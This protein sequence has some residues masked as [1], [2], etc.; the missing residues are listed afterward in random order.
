MRKEIEVRIHEWE[1]YIVGQEKKKLS[2]RDDF[3][4]GIIGGTYERDKKLAQCQEDIQAAE[5]EIKALKSKLEQSD[6]SE[7]LSIKQR[8]RGETGHETFEMYRDA[9][10]HAF[11][12][13]KADAQN[14]I[15]R[16]Q[17]AQNV[18][19]ATKPET[20]TNRFDPWSNVENTYTWF[21]GEFKS[22]EE[23]AF[24]I[25]IALFGGISQ[26]EIFDAFNDIKH[27]LDIDLSAKSDETFKSPTADL[28]EVADADF[29]E[30]ERL[31]NA[32]FIKTTAINFRD[33]RASA[34]IMLMLCRYYHKRE[35]PKV[36]KFLSQVALD[37]NSGAVRER[38]SVA[39]GMFGQIEFE[40]IQYPYLNEWAKYPKKIT[41][42]RHAV[43]IILSSIYQP[44]GKF[45]DN[46]FALVKHWAS[47]PWNFNLWLTATVCCGRLGILDIDK[48]LPI[49]KKLILHDH[50]ELIDPLI[51][52]TSYIFQGSDEDQILEVLECFCRWI[53][54]GNETLQ[55]GTILV[56]VGWM[57]ITLHRDFRRLI[58]PA[59]E[60]GIEI[61]FWNLPVEYNGENTLDFRRKYF[62]AL[63]SVFA[64]GLT[65]GPIMAREI[66][67]LLREFLLRAE[68]RQRYR[69]LFRDIYADLCCN[70]A[71]PLALRQ[72]VMNSLTQIHNA[73]KFR[74]YNFINE[75]YKYVADRYSDK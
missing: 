45:N 25:T 27:I 59:L 29:T 18:S 56:L 12:A 68:Y 16:N 37:G 41:V 74:G 42:S 54:S 57:H 51:Y 8:F 66:I 33:G 58:I 15:P 46:V 7:E 11:T 22:Q 40:W 70:V 13:I 71:H 5:A 4:R 49:L 1:S 32:G 63:T 14:R 53:K 44:N 52:S 2:I 20:T 31:T 64:A 35:L 75:V 60:R 21:T 72:R 36:L 48:T 73:P 9:R 55:L 69:P 17:F 30:Y 10:E 28:I 34:L 67:L 61:D 50:V 24:I 47:I 39:L 23:R 43:S 6:L 65:L 26:K 19:E 3:D 38:A 62:E